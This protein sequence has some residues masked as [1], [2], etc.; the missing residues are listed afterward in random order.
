MDS[1]TP[2]GRPSCLL[3]HPISV[4]PIC[5]SSLMRDGRETQRTQ[6]KH[7]IGHMD[8]KRPRHQGQK[9][10]LQ[11]NRILGEIVVS[12]KRRRRY[13]KAGHGWTPASNILQRALCFGILNARDTNQ[14]H[15]Q[16][17]RSP[18]L[19]LPLPIPLPV[20]I[21]LSLSLSPSPS[22][23]LSAGSTYIYIY[24]LCVC[25]CL[26]VCVCVSVCL[27][28]CVSVS[29]SVS[30]SLSVSVSVAVSVCVCMCSSCLCAGSRAHV[31]VV[32]VRVRACVRACGRAGG[33]AMRACHA[34]VPCGRAMRACHAGVP[35]V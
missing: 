9:A 34:G 28:V 18:C 2:S 20:S 7:V 1:P 31:C 5:P 30:V 16:R 13:E 35:C 17:W 6:A 29:V 19:S 23:A 22:L 12:E 8:A 27:C 4:R 21:S 15:A 11:I 26:S 25:V 32:W 14:L 24:I 10:K 3:S 33:R